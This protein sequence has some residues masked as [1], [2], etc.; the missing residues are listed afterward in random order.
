MK[1]ASLLAR[2]RPEEADLVAADLARIPGVSL[3]GVAPDGGRLVVM[4]EDGEGYAVSDLILAVSITPR[5]LGT[6]LA[7]EYTDED[8]T[9]AEINDAFAKS[10][11]KQEENRS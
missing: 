9:L 3:H 10:R 7:Y 4:V 11:A 8:A 1:I 5:V 2:I 6:T